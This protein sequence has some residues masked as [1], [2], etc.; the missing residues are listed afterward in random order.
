MTLNRQLIGPYFLSEVEKNP[1]LTGLFWDSKGKAGK[2]VVNSNDAISCL[3][4]SRV[5]GWFFF[6]E[7]PR[8]KPD[9][10]PRSSKD[11]TGK[12]SLCGTAWGLLEL[13][14]L[15]GE[16]VS[17]TYRALTM[18][19]LSSNLNNWH[20]FTRNLDT[21]GSRTLPKVKQLT[22]SPWFKLRLFA[23][24]Q[25]HAH[26]LLFSVTITEQCD[27]IMPLPSHSSL[28]SPSCGVYLV[29]TYKRQQVNFSI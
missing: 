10:L 28:R 4:T 24:K 1:D 11:Q 2:D 5:P 8:Q 19:R 3:L 27:T 17:N 13:L 29:Y 14:L 15:E 6:S 25:L 20:S 9:C 12:Q 18:R 26:C 7:Q 23:L 22:N 21:E 16:S